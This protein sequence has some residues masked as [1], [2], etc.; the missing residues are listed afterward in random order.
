MKENYDVNSFNEH[1]TPMPLTFDNKMVNLHVK[2]QKI[3]SFNLFLS[4]IF[5]CFSALTET[6]TITF[7]IALF[8]TEDA[9]NSVFLWFWFLP[10]KV[11]YLLSVAPS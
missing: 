6:I 2:V 5:L 10:Q 3:K 11:F 9:S 7:L 4:V 8:T 1:L